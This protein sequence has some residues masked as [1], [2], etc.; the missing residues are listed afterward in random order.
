MNTKILEHLKKHNE[1]HGWATDEACIIET[2]TE[3]KVIWSKKTSQHRWWNDIFRVVKIN[4]MLIGYDYAEATG[5]NSLRDL[6]WEFNMES[7]CEVK[8]KE[9]KTIIYEKINE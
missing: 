9:I 1:K 5:D 6:G 8:P 3:A 2:L 4:G 7:I